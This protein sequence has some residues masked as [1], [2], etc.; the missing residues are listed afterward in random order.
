L[1]GITILEIGAIGPGPFACM[2]LADMGAEVIRVDRP[3]QEFSGTPELMLRN[4]K[5]ILCDLKSEQGSEVVLRLMENADG[6][7]EGFRPGVMERLGL[8]PDVCL[9]RHPGLVYGRMTGWGQE[10]P[11]AQTAGHDI[12]YISLSGVL[13]EIG[14]DGGRPVVPLNLI[15]DFGGGGMLLAFGM[16][17]ALLEV[18]A[19]GKGQVID[20]AMID[21]SSLMMSLFHGLK[22][23]GLHQEGAGNSFLGGA[24]HYYDTYETKDGKFVSIGALEPQFY[25]LLIEKLGL[26]PQRF[27]AHGFS[28]TN[29]DQGSREGWKELKR[30]LRAVF[31]TR[32][33]DK[34]CELLEGS[35]ACFSPVLTLSEAAEHVHAKA[36]NAFIHTGSGVQPAPAPR[37]S[38]SVPD[39][40]RPFVNAGEHTRE[41]LAR[42]GYPEI[43]IE[44]LFTQKVIA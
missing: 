30:E 29:L 33:R 34:W 43:E 28:F 13:H 39:R 7:V 44:H 42:A 16:V 2:M 40:P 37:F 27:A 3:G 32:S 4:R 8:G 21:G 15:G 26:D 35:D 24:A 9:G 11:L 41:V 22:A 10:G 36:R 5:S 31:K 14:R 6:I 20:A 38:R 12:N 1:E 17:C 19:S 18:K 25:Q 23:M